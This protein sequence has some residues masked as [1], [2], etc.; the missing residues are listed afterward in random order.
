MK[1]FAIIIIIL[2]FN[3]CQ[4]IEMLDNNFETTSDVAPI[5]QSSTLAQRYGDGKFV[6]YTIKVPLTEN[7][8]G[9]YELEEILGNEVLNSEQKSFLDSAIDSIKLSFYS[10]IIELGFSNHMKLSA[11]LKLPRVSERIIKAAKVKKVFFTSEECRLENKNCNGVESK[12]LLSNFDLISQLFI[13]VSTSSKKG[14]EGVDDITA[15][16]FKKIKKTSTSLAQK[17]TLNQEI[18]TRDEI[19]I[20]DYVNKGPMLSKTKY[21]VLNGKRGVVFF[22]KTDKVKKLKYLRSEKF[23]DIIKSARYRKRSSNRFQAQSK[24]DIYVKL[25]KG[26]KPKQ[27][28]EKI[29][30][31][32]TPFL[33]RTF[34]I[35]LNSKLIETK[36]YLSSERFKDIIKDVSL[37]GRSLFIQVR[38]DNAIKQFKE[39]LQED[40]K[41]LNS[42]LDI[43]DIDR[44]SRHNCLDLEVSNLNLLPL[45]TSSDFLN[46][47]TYLS[48]E[49]LK[50]VD[51]MYNGYVEV[52]L[53]LDLSL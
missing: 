24:K 42:D 48:L 7:S 5:S 53:T 29:R 2:S 30:G 19:N 40:T 39:T 36:K 6:T 37:V 50:A 12:K 41:F 38:N 27:L 26:I 44:C 51:F 47:N 4:L 52:E 14:F 49:S 43:L 11:S 16:E 22:A 8:L 17:I 28:L 46:I 13:N 32:E 20:I 3:S 18:D 25:R 34:I 45:I 10:F 35:R 21:K 1:L 15:E 31:T 23:K 9:Y 33:R